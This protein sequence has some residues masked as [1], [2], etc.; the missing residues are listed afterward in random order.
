MAALGWP[1]G[2]EHV[3]IKSL[4]NRIRLP[5]DV[6]NAIRDERY[7]SLRTAHAPHFRIKPRKIEPVRGLGYGDEIDSRIRESAS[8]SRSHAIFD[9]WMRLG[10]FDL[11]R[12]GVRGN[13]P[14]KASGEKNGELPGAAPAIKRELRPTRARN[15][16][17][18]K[19]RW[20]GRTVGGVSFGVGRKMIL[21]RSHGGKNMTAAA[22]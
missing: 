17:V 15:K 22:F 19:R 21:E 20:I 14:I 16:E 1:I 13:N 2:A 12:A 11:R 18:D 5:F 10:V 4:R 7:G 8:F 3:P 9:L 6:Q